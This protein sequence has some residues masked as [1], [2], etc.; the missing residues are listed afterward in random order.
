MN[1]LSADASVK[2]ALICFHLT[3]AHIELANFSW[4]NAALEGL[5]AVDAST[6]ARKCSSST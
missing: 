2:H 3:V 6:S 5:V 1:C 4:H